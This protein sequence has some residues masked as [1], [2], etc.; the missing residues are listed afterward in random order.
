[1][2][3]SS[4]GLFCAGGGK[5]KAYKALS[6]GALH[7][8]L[9]CTTDGS[10]RDYVFHGSNY[11]TLKNDLYDYGI[12]RKSD[13]GQLWTFA[14][15]ECIEE[16]VGK[17]STVLDTLIEIM[18]DLDLVIEHQGLVDTVS[19]NET[20]GYYVVPDLWTRRLRDCRGEKCT[21]AERVPVTYDPRYHVTLA[22]R[23]TVQ[24]WLLNRFFRKALCEC[25]RTLKT[26]GSSWREGTMTLGTDALRWTS[27][28]WP[29]GPESFVF[30][31]HRQGIDQ[32]M[33]K[34]A[35]LEHEREKLRW[36]YLQVVRI[37]EETMEIERIATRRKELGIT[38]R[39]DS[40]ETEM[41]WLEVAEVEKGRASGKTT[42][43]RSTSSSDQCSIS[44]FY[45]DEAVRDDMFLP[46]FES[47][48]LIPRKKSDPEFLVRHRE[49]GPDSYD[50][51]QAQLTATIDAIMEGCLSDDDHEH[52][53]VAVVNGSAKQQVVESR[54]R[55]EKAEAQDDDDCKSRARVDVFVCHPLRNW[56][57]P[58]ESFYKTILADFCEESMRLFHALRMRSAK[59][60]VSSSATDRPKTDRASSSECKLSIQRSWASPP[61][62][63]TKAFELCHMHWFFLKEPYDA[64]QPAAYGLDLT[65]ARNAVLAIKAKR[66]EGTIELKPVGTKCTCDAP[67]EVVYLAKVAQAAG[68]ELDYR[69]EA[70]QDLEITCE[71]SLFHWCKDNDAQWK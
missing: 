44:L 70:N 29:E 20:P 35:G 68:R 21:E 5:S 34:V 60:V 24:G 47:A 37:L 41:V 9:L 63:Q 40:G 10:C 64:V 32:I 4:G 51:E 59:V 55:I 48:R 46:N 16:S 33:I 11:R 66:L 12:I 2:P 18:V 31:L 3:F 22:C 39:A 58:I 19:A 6:D 7:W 67:E 38:P 69:L 54:V 65:E 52:P 1:M 28:S 45:F 8:W 27:A 61:R 49:C 14:D 50:S 53:E 62:P 57:I 42:L 25:A 36:V 30:C 13:L 56:Y 15:E 71:F 17:V 43:E 26:M 23:F